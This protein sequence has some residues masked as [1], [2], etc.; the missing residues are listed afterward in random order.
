MS[1]RPRC[2]EITKTASAKIEQQMAKDCSP[3]KCLE[4][5]LNTVCLYSSWPSMQKAVSHTTLYGIRIF[6]GVSLFE[7]ESPPQFKS[8]Q[9][10]VYFAKSPPQTSTPSPQTRIELQ[11][12]QTCIEYKLIL[13]TSP[14]T[15]IQYKSTSTQARKLAFKGPNTHTSL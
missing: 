11:V 5:L 13:N 9:T 3:S 12:Q 1:S 4:L 2:S 7:T 14:Q 15:R 10:R 6:Q 8:P